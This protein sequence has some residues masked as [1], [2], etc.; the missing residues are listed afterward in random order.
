M[1]PYPSNTDHT[2]QSNITIPGN[3]FDFTNT[4]AFTIS[5]WINVALNTEDQFIMGN[6]MNNP[7]ST[8]PD[9]TDHQYIGWEIWRQCLIPGSKTPDRLS[10]LFCGEPNGWGGAK[11]PGLREYYSN[12]IGNS[13]GVALDNNG[14]HHICFTKS[15]SGMLEN[16]HVKCYVDGQLINLSLYNRNITGGALQDFDFRTSNAPSLGGPVN[17]V[18]NDFHIGLRNGDLTGGNNYYG[19][20]DFLSDIRIYNY[21]MDINAIQSLMT[22]DYFQTPQLGWWIVGGPTT[23]DIDFI[24][25]YSGAGNHG[26][27]RN[28]NWTGYGPKNHKDTI[29]S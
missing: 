2:Q 25:D 24:R 13:I 17:G 3:D 6:R 8:H 19:N 16:T 21:E 27:G 1:N 15:A 28:I 26:V 10:I 29:Y 23:N 12:D 9:D 5:F 22:L 4:S 7:T 20:A 11:G 18:A 14:W